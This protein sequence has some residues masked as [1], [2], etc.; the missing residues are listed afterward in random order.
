MPRWRPLAAR[1]T[2]RP[3]PKSTA[4]AA[5][6]G[7]RGHLARPWPATG[8]STHLQP[9]DGSSAVS[10]ART[11]GQAAGGRAAGGG[12]CVSAGARAVHFLC[13]LQLL[14]LL[15]RSSDGFQQPLSICTLLQADQQAAAAAVAPAAGIQPHRRQRPL[16]HHACGGA[17]AAAHTMQQQRSPVTVTRTC[18]CT[19][20]PCRSC[21]GRLPGCR[22]WAC[23][24][25]GGRRAPAAGGMAAQAAGPH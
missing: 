25:S 22:R 10:A 15:Y 23:G 13:G 24:G 18:P 2:R 20:Q 3:L 21:Q 16:G 19:C 17:C 5:N 8:R 7:G 12:R 14:N 9:L 4:E 6:S 11:P 1:W